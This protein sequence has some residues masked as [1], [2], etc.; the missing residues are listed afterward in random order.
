LIGDALDIVESVGHGDRRFHLVGHDWDG[1]LSWLIADRW[2][3][4]IASL[5]MLSRPHPA[6]FARAMKTDPEQPH[7]SRHH[8]ELLDPGAGARLLA[9]TENGFATGWR[10]TACRKPRLTSTCP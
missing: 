2:P 4:R 5:T 10:A 9:D 8:H 1:S 7:R 6:S 3:E